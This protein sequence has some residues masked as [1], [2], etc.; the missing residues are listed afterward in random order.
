MNTKMILIILAFLTIFGVGIWL[1]LPSSFFQSK[2][3]QPLVTYRQFDVKDFDTE[4]DGNYTGTFDTTVVYLMTAS[5]TTGNFE[6][7]VTVNGTRSFS[8]LQITGIYTGR[9][10]GN[11]DNQSLSGAIRGSISGANMTGAIQVSNVKPIQ[12]QTDSTPWTLI[13][14][15]LGIIFVLI[16]GGYIYLNYK[17]KDWEDYE[18]IEVV[19]EYVRPIILSKYH[20]QIK[21][22]RDSISIPRDRPKLRKIFYECYDGE[23]IIA[24]VVRAKLVDL[25]TNVPPSRY[26]KE[27]E[28]KHAYMRPYDDVAKPMQKKGG[29]TVYRPLP[30][31]GKASETEYRY[32]P[33]ENK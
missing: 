21:C 29:K 5:K 2:N 6:G 24:F 32:S 3:A 33:D 23:L 15:V 25:Q 18:S 27:L 8:R 7:F 10:F 28:E 26:I 17:S 31:I 30:K 12:L 19:D 13:L 14:L 11:I 9:V 1:A 16:I 22:F 4:L 20:R